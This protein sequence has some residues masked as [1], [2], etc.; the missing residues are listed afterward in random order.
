MPLRKR[1]QSSQPIGEPPIRSCLREG[2]HSLRSMARLHT[3]EENATA[4]TAIIPIPLLTQAGRPHNLA[5]AQADNRSMLSRGNRR[6]TS[7]GEQNAS[8]DVRPS[9]VRA[10]R[11]WRKIAGR[12]H[13]YSLR[14]GMIPGQ[15]APQY[16]LGRIRDCTRPGSPWMRKNPSASV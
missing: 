3:I 16:F 8:H 12:E 9:A 14:K 5:P 6:K 15:P 11:P 10:S 2:L 13:G 7:I 4:A 1:D